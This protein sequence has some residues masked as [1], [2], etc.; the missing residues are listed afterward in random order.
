[1]AE[2]VSIIIPVYHAEDT[3]VRCVESLM[4]GVYQDLEILLVEDCSPDNS[5]EVC[6][7]LQMQYSCVKAYRNDHN[8]GPSATRNRGLKEITGTFLMFVDSD[9]WVEPD[10]V[11]SFVDAWKKYHPDL[12]ACGYWNHDEVQN[13][14]TDYF[15]WGSEAEIT[16]TEL[17]AALLAMY[18]GRLLQQIWNKFFLADVV[19]VHNL[20]FDTSIR[21]GEDFRFLLS[22]L[23]RV[24]GNKLVR[25]NWP[26]Y[27]YIRCSGN[28]LM[29]QFGR[30]EIHEPL[31]NLERLYV[32]IGMSEAERERKLLEDRRT[33]TELW[34]YLIMHNMG[35]RRQEK[36]KM[37]LL[38]DTQNGRKLYHRNWI[39]YMKERILV[40]LKRMGL[41]R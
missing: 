40:A 10:Y 8:S 30:E 25:I 21:M 24:P 33:Q 13:A 16:V 12:I 28:S 37:I 23:E 32:L 14:S 26:L 3:L 36:K 4:C 39:V 18:E 22:Y 35:M 2:T 17:N 15:G 19:R 20:S 6:Q 7:K 34:A 41:K 5:W 31:K 9:D 38:L 11:S 29:S 27:H 1:M